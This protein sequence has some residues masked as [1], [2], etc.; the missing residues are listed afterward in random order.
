MSFGW[1][2]LM[3]SQVLQLLQSSVL[4]H[5]S[6]P[7]LTTHTHSRVPCR[8]LQ[9]CR[10]RRHWG[11]LHSS[12]ARLYPSPRGSPGPSSRLQPSASCHPNTSYESEPVRRH[13][14]GSY[15]SLIFLTT[16]YRRHTLRYY[17]ARLKLRVSKYEIT[18]VTSERMDLIRRDSESASPIPSGMSVMSSIAGDFRSDQACFS[19][20]YGFTFAR[21]FA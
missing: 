5:L 3:A 18:H 2:N 19:R 8:L 9:R 14:S 6:R 12:R 21:P 20:T 13:G 1:A 16:I 10:R 15:T 11:Q 4:G 7:H 17:P